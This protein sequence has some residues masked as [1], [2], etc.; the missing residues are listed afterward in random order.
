MKPQ[1]LELPAF[2]VGTWYRSVRTLDELSI[3]RENS[4]T[5]EEPQYYWSSDGKWYKAEQIYK[6]KPVHRWKYFLRWDDSIRADFTLKQIERVP[7]KLRRIQRDLYTMTQGRQDRSTI[8][9][10]LKRCDDAQSLCSFL[11]QHN[12]GEKA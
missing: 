4:I 2:H 3:V 10:E 6:V 1:E 5:E 12:L 11:E 7:V 9:A 8:R